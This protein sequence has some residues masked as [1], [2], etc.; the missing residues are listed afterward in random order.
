RVFGC[1]DCQSICPWNKFATPTREDDF[2]PRHALDRA[3]LVDLFAWSEE[4]FL[5]HTEGSAIRRIG[6]ACW[7]RNLAVAL[8]N[9]PGTAEVLAALESRRHHPSELVREHVDWALRRHG[10]AERGEADAGA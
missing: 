1:D 10:R 2:S 7:L 5:R 9:A 6:Y 3:Q 8:G 4:D